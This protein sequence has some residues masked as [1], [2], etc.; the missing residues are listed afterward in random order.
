ML[1]LIDGDFLGRRRAHIKTRIV[2]LER[3]RVA[4]KAH[5]NLHKWTKASGGKTESAWSGRNEAVEYQSSCGGVRLR[6]GNL[7]S[8]GHERARLR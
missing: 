1:R 4:S 5:V 7:K 6:P 3:G 2:W 8:V